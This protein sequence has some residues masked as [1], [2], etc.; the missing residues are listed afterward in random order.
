MCSSDL[1]R[2]FLLFGSGF[3]V[4]QRMLEIF[5]Q[6]Y[7]AVIGKLGI[8]YQIPPMILGLSGIFLILFLFDEVIK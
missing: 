2:K 6:E 8:I 4:L 1:A 7:Q 3:F 5:L